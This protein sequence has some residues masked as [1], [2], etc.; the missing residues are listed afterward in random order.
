MH[1]ECDEDRRRTSMRQYV[2]AISRFTSE[3]VL[4]FIGIGFVVLRA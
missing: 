3:V 2:D 4:R 1:G